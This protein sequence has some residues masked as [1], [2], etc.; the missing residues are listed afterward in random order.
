MLP[1]T[2]RG[3]ENAMSNS[4][5][6]KTSRICRREKKKRYAEGRGLLYLL[7]LLSLRLIAMGEEEEEIVCRICRCEATDA[8]PL[9]QPCRCAGSVGLVHE[10]CLV[11]WL[12]Y[13]HKDA[14]ELCKF[15]YRFSPVYAPSTPDTLPWR[16]LAAAA[17][18]V[19]AQL[20]PLYCLPCS[21]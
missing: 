3:G 18:R 19:S 16:T 9:L 5:L 12:A 8:S 13:S 7:L 14:C 2:V 21:L 6:A 20:Y 4:S 10:N 11:Q 1:Y 15:K 17:V